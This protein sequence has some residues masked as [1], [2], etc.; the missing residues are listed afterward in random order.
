MAS[1]TDKSFGNAVKAQEV[2]QLKGL[3]NLEKRLCKAEKKI[4][5]AQLER[6]L[7]LQ[8]ELFP[9]QSLQERRNNFSAFYLENGDLLKDKLINEL[10]PLSPYFTI[11]TL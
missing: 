6:I 8:N 11:I 9:N 4:Y 5:A 10:K 2:K 1:G 7:E 3:E